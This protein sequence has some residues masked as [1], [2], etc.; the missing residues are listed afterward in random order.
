MFKPIFTITPEINSQIAEIE[1]LRT[2]V[3]QATILPELEVQL[4]FRA[5]VEAVHSSTSIEGNPLNEQQVQKVLQGQTITAPDYAI[6]EILN[7]KRAIDWLNKKE[8]S[9]KDLTTKDI[10]DLHGIVTAKL[11][12][13][14]KSGNWRPSDVFVVDEIDGQE[15]VQY[16]GPEAPAVSRLVES[17]L[18]WVKLQSQ[19]SLHPVLLAG[20]IHYIFVSIHPFSDGN[21]RTTRLL[22]YYFLKKWSYDFRGS[23]SLDSFYLQHRHEYYDALSRGKTFDDRMVSDVTP[24]LEFFTKGFLEAVTD[25]SQYIKV[26]KITS[27]GEKPM[28]LDGDELALL[29]FVYQFGAITIQEAIGVLQMPKRTVQRRLMELVNKKI[30]TIEGQGPATQYVMSAK[31]KKVA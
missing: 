9:N 8:N 7:Y 17:F 26:G 24:F 21:G 13:N 11:L 14:E 28:R 18:Q 30:L 3:D 20:L 23:L 22:T 16:T 25:L 29:D 6:V 27:K 15:I 19:S 10:L 31:T 2:I 4:R 1:K 12:P 5:T